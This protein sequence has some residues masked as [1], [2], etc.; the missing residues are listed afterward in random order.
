VIKDGL[1]SQ[2]RAL[3]SI[4]KKAWL[5]GGFVGEVLLDGDDGVKDTPGSLE[6]G[7]PASWKGFASSR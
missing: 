6:C 5:G 2:P 3:E 1:K 4:G 7:S